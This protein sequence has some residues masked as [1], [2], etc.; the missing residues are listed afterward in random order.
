METF[1]SF[2]SNSK[3]LRNA[4]CE[5]LNISYNEEK[6]ILKVNGNGIITIIETDSISSCRTELDGFDRS[7]IMETREGRRIIFRA[8]SKSGTIK[9]L[10]RLNQALSKSNCTLR[11]TK[12]PSEVMP[13][14]ATN[15]VESNESQRRQP[16]NTSAIVSVVIISAFA[17][18]FGFLVNFA[19]KSNNDPEIKSPVAEDAWKARLDREQEEWNKKQ[20]KELAEQKQNI[21]LSKNKDTEIASVIVSVSCAGNKGLIPRNQ[22]GSMMKDIFD[23]KGINSTEVFE[24]WDYYWNIAKEMDAFNKTYCL[25]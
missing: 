20:E 6:E 10:A 19:N 2:D 4:R 1:H 18:I 3:L 5:T 21:P 12:E 8:D 24:N 9:L 16:V 11:F 22:M 14:L 17:V 25:K 7:L 23:D 15:N 13:I